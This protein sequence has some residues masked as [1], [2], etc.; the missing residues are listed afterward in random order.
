MLDHLNLY[1]KEG[2]VCSG[3][4]SSS[5]SGDGSDNGQPFEIQCAKA[6]HQQDGGMMT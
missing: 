1:I 4:G 5:R 6:N 3:D 2:L